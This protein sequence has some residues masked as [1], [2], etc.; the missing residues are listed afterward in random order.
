MRPP[1]AAHHHDRQLRGV[2]AA[3]HHARAIHEHRVVKRRAVA[4]LNRVELAGDVGDL[5]EEELIHLQ[6][7]GRIGVGKAD[8]GSCNRR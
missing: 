3:G 8:G 1:P 4:F 7:V 6:P 2:V 5:L